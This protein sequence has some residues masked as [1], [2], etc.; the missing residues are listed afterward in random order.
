MV[1]I[2]V[3][4]E[5]HLRLRNSLTSSNSVTYSKPASISA[6]ASSMILATL[7]VY[8]SDSKVIK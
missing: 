1:V 4:K 8:S 2:K 3:K 6:A 5:G 7:Q